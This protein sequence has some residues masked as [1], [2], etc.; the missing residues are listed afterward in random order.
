ILNEVS[1]EAAAVDPVEPDKVCRT[2]KQIGADLKLVLTTHHHWLFLVRDRDHAGGNEKMKQL[3][4]G[5]KVFGGSK[6]SV[7][8]CTDNLENGDKLP[9][10]PDLEILAL[11]TPWYGVAPVVSHLAL[12][13]L[14]YRLELDNLQARVGCGTP[15]EALR[16]IRTM[17]DNWR[18]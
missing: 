6:D 9:L 14:S 3:V 11:H 12:H 18:G 4:P 17:K 13:T 16:K 7:K 1:G 8:G 15:V 2:A 5:I 10:G